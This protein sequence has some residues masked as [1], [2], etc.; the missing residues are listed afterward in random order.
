ML[1]GIGPGPVKDKLAVGIV[2]EIEGNDTG[3]RTGFIVG[4]KMSRQPAKGLADTVMPF[5]GRQKL[6]PQTGIAGARR[7]VP[8]GSR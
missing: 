8:L 6:V 4:D 3:R 2:L 5:Q 7:P 1:I